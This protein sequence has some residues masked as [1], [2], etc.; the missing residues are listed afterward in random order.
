V[1]ITLNHVSEIEATLSSPT[2]ITGVTSTTG[3]LL[4]VAII[5]DPA[6]TISAVTDSKNNT[7]VSC[8]SV[9]T[10]ATGGKCYIF[11]SFSATTAVTSVKLTSSGSGA[12]SVGVYDCS[13]TTGGALDTAVAYSTQFSETNTQTL[14]AAGAGICISLL[15]NQADTQTIAAPFTNDNML[16]SQITGVAEGAHYVNGSGGSITANW[17]AFGSNQH[18]SGLIA[19]YK[20]AS[21]AAVKHRLPLLGVGQ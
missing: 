1:A 18:W 13:S 4:I 7:Y 10:D 14:T 3:N 12:A 2:T 11:A 16:D 8:G 20:E 6:V 17:T 5:C 9:G 15:A 21:A 19:E